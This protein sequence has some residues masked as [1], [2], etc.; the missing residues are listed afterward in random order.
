MALQHKQ[1]TQQQQR[2]LMAPNIT[3]ALEVLR[4]HAME[5]QAFL[6]QQA[7]ENPLLEVDESNQ[8]E[9]AVSA[10]SESD[11][12]QEEEKM[13]IAG[14]E[15]W[16]SHWQTGGSE[17]DPEEGEPNRL[18]EQRLVQPQSLHESLLVQLGCQSISDEQ[19]RIGEAIIE[20]LNEY[21]Y[22]EG[23]L[24]E[25]AA[26]LGMTLP[27]VEAVL[28]IVQRFDPPGVGARD[29]RECLMLQLEQKN[30]CGGLA[31]RILRDHFPLFVQHRLSALAS[32]VGASLADIEQAYACLT[33]LNPKP[34]RLFTNDLPPTIVPDLVI[35]RRDRHYDVEL[36]DQDMP[37]IGIS[38]VYYRM[39]KD[40]RTPDDAREFL[41]KKFRQA[42]WI[43][44]AIDE[45]NATILAI[46]RCLI[47]LQREFVEQGP[48]AMKPL[49]QA[50]VAHL[51]G[52]HP[53]TVSRA[54]AGKTIDTPYGVFRLEQ[55]FAS[56]VPQTTQGNSDVSDATIK[57]EIE[58][59]IEEED[60]QH[61]LSDDALVKRLSQRNISV[62]RRTIAKYRTSLKI[63]PGHLRRHR[64]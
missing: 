3:L 41:L 57:A 31:Y 11:G 53:S 49:T 28:N 48:K 2:L 6:Q 20:A 22:C 14:D 33:R 7:Q 9:E 16:L 21:G 30:A 15:D 39:L 56:S 61:P 59:L 64:L 43:I 51:I 27:Q 40:S 29:L 32:A 13:P 5:L 17:E 1:S 60:S 54:I 36:N 42:S 8:D 25:L 19:H 62:A 63:L 26:Q 4:M 24:E 58:R 47:S 50:Q 52:R 44:K 45:R 12:P 18:L 10:P 23:S 55:L 35:Q 38:R 34:A 37:Q 46:G